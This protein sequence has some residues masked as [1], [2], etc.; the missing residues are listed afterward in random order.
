MDLPLSKNGQLKA[1][2]LAPITGGGLLRSDAAASWNLMVEA[3]AKDGITLRH[4]GAYR[5]ETIQ[6]SLFKTNYTPIANGS[7]DVRLW[8]SN[9]NGSKERW[10]RRPNKPSTAIP[11]TSNHGWGTAIDVANAFYAYGAAP[12]KIVSWLNRNA[13]KF[14]WVRPSWAFTQRDWEPWH[15]EYDPSKDTTKAKSPNLAVDGVFGAKTNRAWREQLGGLNPND[16]F[17]PVAIKRLQK[18]LNGKNGKGG[19]ELSAGPLK[20]TGEFDKRTVA[21]VQKLINLWIKKHDLP[22]TKLKVD[23][24]FGSATRKAIQFTLNKRLWD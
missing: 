7:N 18:R 2:E 22:L 24:D 8:D 1:S 10:Y 13:K 19:Y 14:G 4:N 12:S 17:G 6:V 5:P 20:L 11:G 16:E 9:G 23:G 3:A 21:A 15:W